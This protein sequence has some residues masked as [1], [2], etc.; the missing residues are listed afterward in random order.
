MVDPLSVGSVS[1]TGDLRRRQTG[2]KMFVAHTKHYIL[3]ISW[4]LHQ[5]IFNRLNLMFWI[6]TGCCIAHFGWRGPKKHLN[7]TNL[8]QKLSLGTSRSG[9]PGTSRDGTMGPWGV[10]QGPRG[11]VQGIRGAALC[12][13]FLQ[14]SYLFPTSTIWKS[15]ILSK[16][17]I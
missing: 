4:I 9:A 16:L 17:L 6:L 14:F 15:E 3:K 2:H 13:C 7:L 1:L 11:A 12:Y 10:V 8:S 5:N